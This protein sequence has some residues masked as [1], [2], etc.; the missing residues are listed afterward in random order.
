MNRIGVSSYAKSALIGGVAKVVFDIYLFDA[1]Q[2]PRSDEG[3][4]IPYSAVVSNSIKY[5]EAV[6]SDGYALS[7][8]TLNTIAFSF[9]P[10]LASGYS[11]SFDFKG[12]SICVYYRTYYDKAS[13]GTFY[14]T[15]PITGGSDWFRYR[16]A[17]N[18][19]GYN[20]YEENDTYLTFYI[21]AHTVSNNGIVYVH[22]Y[23][24]LV[25]CDFDYS[26]VFFGCV[27]PPASEISLLGSQ[28]TGLLVGV[29]GSYGDVQIPY[30]YSQPPSYKTIFGERI[31]DLA[32]SVALKQ[33]LTLRQVLDYLLRM[34]GCF[35]YYD[36]VRNDYHFLSFMDFN[37]LSPNANNII[38]DTMVLSKEFATSDITITGVRVTPFDNTQTSFM[39]GSDGYV[40]DIRDN[41]LVL[42]SN[43][44][45]V[46]QY[47]GSVY[48]GLSFRT[49][50]VKM[51][52]NFGF[53]V[54]EIVYYYDEDKQEYIRLLISSLDWSDGYSMTFE[55]KANT[56]VDQA[57]LR[58]VTNVAIPTSS[59]SQQTL[60][61]TLV[62]GNL[63]VTGTKSRSINSADFGERLLY[64]YEMAEPVFGDFGEGII[65][66]DGIC[67]IDIDPI[68]ADAI[69]TG[70]YQ[71][72]IQPYGEGSA[73]VS[74]RQGDRFIV[75]GSVGLRFAWELKARQLGYDQLRL[76][77][78]EAPEVAVRPSVI[79]VD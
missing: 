26:Q 8:K 47:I 5:K 40:L 68:L 75:V 34:Y 12:A 2:D 63:Q 35:S 51:K 28:K 58:F 27:S 71:V 31:I 25:K 37:S 30:W 52:S 9:I 15:N 4:L 77:P 10:S 17:S 38:D 78:V 21:D 79:H 14:E 57:D 55:S 70:Q 39:Y 6:S 72:F 33:N 44:N 32:T 29:S 23:E 74:E 50:K 53:C 13:A 19:Y 24:E 76:E 59:P 69:V 49:G 73:Y 7:G 45:R 11:D 22:A 41:P 43:A 56:D 67:V 16:F 42:S 66:Q 36:A 18:D 64:A 1:T 61:N 54:G 65:G 20:G 62:R 48:V 3:I 60:S 46:A